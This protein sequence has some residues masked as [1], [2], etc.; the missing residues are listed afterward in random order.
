MQPSYSAFKFS[1]EEMNRATYSILHFICVYLPSWSVLEMC[2]PKNYRRRLRPSFSVVGSFPYQNSAT[3]TMNRTPTIFSSVS[4]L[5]AGRRASAWVALHSTPQG[6]PALV[7][8]HTINIYGLATE[9]NKATWRTTMHA[10]LKN[11]KKTVRVAGLPNV[12]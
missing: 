2:D 10:R 7:Y 8:M 6:I 1:G 3:A 5:A 12:I 4:G 11:M 9:F